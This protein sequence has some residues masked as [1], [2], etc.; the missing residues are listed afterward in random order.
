MIQ[1]IV[2]A[3]QAIAAKT[4]AVSPIHFLGARKTDEDG[5]PTPVS[6]PTGSVGTDSAKKGEKL[7]IN[8]E[9][10]REYS[11]NGQK[12]NYFA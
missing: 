8:C 3:N 1:P 10:C 2:T 6:I 11:L 9:G 5:M 12:I 4:L 7:D